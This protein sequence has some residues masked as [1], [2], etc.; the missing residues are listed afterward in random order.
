[1]HGSGDQ[2]TNG[3]S[4]NHA[5]QAEC[6]LVGQALLD[7]FD[8]AT[9]WVAQ[10]TEDADNDTKLEVNRPI[11]PPQLLTGMWQLY[12]LYKQASVG[13]CSVPKPS[14]FNVKALYKWSGP[15]QSG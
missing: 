3:Q 15:P 10:N 13:D 7:E 8:T 14:D 6:T 12:G 1:M 5:K 2:S 9:T 11:A 4:A